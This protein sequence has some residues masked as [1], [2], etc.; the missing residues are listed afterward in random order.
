M[1][2][3]WAAKAAYIAVPTTLKLSYSS[4]IYS[5]RVYIAVF[6]FPV[7]GSIILIGS[8]STGPTA[9]TP[10]LPDYFETS[11]GG[12]VLFSFL[13][14]PKSSVHSENYAIEG[15]QINS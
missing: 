3:K 14:N 8:S 15:K 7:F 5:Y 11:M 10:F 1:F 12:F 13:A 6:F 9:I 2:G 4:T